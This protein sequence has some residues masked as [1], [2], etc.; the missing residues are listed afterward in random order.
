MPDQ[1][2]GGVDGDEPPASGAPAAPGAGAAAA[3][4]APAAPGALVV[5]AAPSPQRFSRDVL[6]NIAS[7]GIAGI[8]GIGL[9]YLIGAVH[10]A[11]VLGVFNQVFAAYLVFSQL[12]ALGVHTS[13]LTHG[14]AERDPGER[15]VIFTA[16]LAVIA[17]QAA[18]M[19]LVFAA[20]SPLVGDLLGSPDVGL[21]MLYAAPGLFCFA[22]NKGALAVLNSLQRM[23]LYAVF[24]AGRVVMMTVGFAGFALADLPPAALPILLTV[25][26]ASVLIAALIAISDQLGR[27]PLR[28]WA[29]VHARFGARG[30]LSGLFS[31]LNTRIDVV[32]LGVFVED[33]VVGAYSFAAI[34]AEGVYQIVIALR[35]NYA[36][37][38]VRLLAARDTAALLAKIAHGRNRTY[39]GAAA[40]AVLAIAGYAL[41]VPLIAGD[42]LIQDS[43][44]YF[45][46]VIAG[47]AASAGYAPF[48]QLL[49]WAGRPGSHTILVALIVGASA[50]ANTVLVQALG[51]T[52]AAIAT[53]A[54]Y[55]WS[56]IALRLLVGKILGLRI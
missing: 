19:A 33:A 14:A 48:G 56:A 29:G 6:W 41:I 44:I 36:P 43:L 20:I 45:A 55:V 21:G 34:L 53:A 54:T 3:P 28:R 47:M 16:G 52:G 32:I 8:C 9:N 5:L 10:G 13:I 27:A 38:L 25:G 37:I 26:E 22:L 24:Q 35:T 49:L 46:I 23:R 30:F 2:A 50:A 31:D 11:R 4:G 7:L 17:A 1:R 12:A 40:V 15:R 42:P 39:A 18:A 51:A